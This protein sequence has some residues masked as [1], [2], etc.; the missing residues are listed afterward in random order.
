MDFFPFGLGI[1]TPWS[2]KT[3]VMHHIFRRKKIEE[4]EKAKPEHRKNLKIWG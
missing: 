4:W 2:G 1:L 3:Y